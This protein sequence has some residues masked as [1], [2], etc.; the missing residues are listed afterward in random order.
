[1]TRLMQIN[2]AEGTWVLVD[3]NE[4]DAGV[5]RVGRVG[6]VIQSSM[7]SL[8]AALAPVCETAA[9]AMRAFRAGLT[10][11]DEIE[12]GFGV[13]LTAEAGAVIAKSGVDAHLDVTVRWARTPP[14]DDTTT[15][16]TPET[17]P[18]SQAPRSVT[19]SSAI[20]TSIGSTFV[21]PDQLLLGVHRM[22]E[23]ADGLES[24]LPD[25]TRLAL[26][27]LTTSD[28]ALAHSIRR[29]LA[30]ADTAEDAIAGFQS[31]I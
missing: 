11:P 29:V 3:I 18:L 25:L 10:T 26:A 21:P 20:Q 13:R 16:S 31:F 4:S 1:M 7:S 22:D 15:S 14:E 17:K 30:A 12:I 23:S 6:D 2:L 5:A 8:E 24:E 27:E 28:D 9:A 19:P